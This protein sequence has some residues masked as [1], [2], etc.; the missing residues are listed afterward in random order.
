LYDWEEI[1]KQVYL[2]LL[3][4]RNTGRNNVMAMHFNPKTLNIN[5]LY[6]DVYS[7]KT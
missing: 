1:Y 4:R 6:L 7:G 3:K 5:P 2:P